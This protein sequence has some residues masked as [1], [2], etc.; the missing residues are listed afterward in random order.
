MAVVL[1]LHQSL[2]HL[3]SVFSVLFCF[4]LLFNEDGLTLPTPDLLNR[5]LEMGLSFKISPSSP[6]AHH[7]FE[8]LQFYSPQ[9]KANTKLLLKRKT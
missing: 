4:V 1:E 9:L 8:K 7:I 6:E 5:K 2:N 3:Y